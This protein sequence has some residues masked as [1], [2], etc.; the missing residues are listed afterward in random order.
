M[1]AM[2]V[3]ICSRLVEIGIIFLVVFAPIYYG[4]VDLEMV[5]VIELT[6]L[7]MVLIWGVETAV[8]GD[9]VFRRTPLDIAI[10]VFCVYCLIFTL[11]L[12]RYAYTRHVGLPLALCISAL[13]FIIVNH[14]WQRPSRIE[15]SCWKA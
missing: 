9:L 5:T 10:L 3:N 15:F 14:I 4:S 8:K 6:I 11:F 2:T 13:Y 1:R 12:S 7:F